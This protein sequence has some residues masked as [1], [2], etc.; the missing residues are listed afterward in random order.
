[1][2]DTYCVYIHTASNGKRYI[3]ITKQ[4]PERRWRNGLGYR[5]NKHFFSAIIKYGWDNITHEIYAEN[6]NQKS[7]EKIERE[8]IKKYQSKDK[9]HGY[10]HTDGGDGTRGFSPSEESRTKMSKSRSGEKNYWYGKNLPEYAK[11]KMSE[12]RRRLCEN[13]A[14]LEMMHE[15]NPNKKKVY[16]YDLEGNLIKI[17]SGA[18]KAEKEFKQGKECQA[19]RKCCTGDCNG[20][21][22]YIWSYKPINKIPILTGYRTVYQY[23]L[24]GN[25][26]EEWENLQKAVNQFREGKESIVIRQCVSGHRPHAYGYLWSYDILNESE[27][28]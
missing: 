27:V 17:W 14:V 2:A 8:L 21:Y 4:A 24:E 12:S 22:G 18:R 6:L 13:P 26:I 28:I 5:R 7:A 1:M 16:Q 15:V 11:K 3:G 23:D 9:M 20:A 25:L 19:I 10:N